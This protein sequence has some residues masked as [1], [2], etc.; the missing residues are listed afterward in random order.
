MTHFLVFFQPPNLGNNFDSL[1]V[2]A[3]EEIVCV[4][5]SLL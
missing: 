4:H 5:F 3:N 1:Y 2:V